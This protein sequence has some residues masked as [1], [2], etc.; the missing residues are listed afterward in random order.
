MES[1]KISMDIPIEMYSWLEKHKNINRSEIFRRAVDDIINNVEKKVSPVLFLLTIWAN[2]GA[3]ALL[4]VSIVPSP[5][6]NLIRGILAVMAGIISISAITVY[7][8]T[9]RELVTQ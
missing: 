3:V 6:P 1:K 2:V 4:G 7:V 9:K 8:R 5:V